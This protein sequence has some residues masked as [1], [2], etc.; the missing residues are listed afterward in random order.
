MVTLSLNVGTSCWLDFNLRPL[1]P[2]LHLS[3]LNWKLTHSTFYW[4]FCS[5]VRPIAKSTRLITCDEWVNDHKLGKVGSELY[6]STNKTTATS[7][8]LFNQIADRFR[9]LWSIISAMQIRDSLHCCSH[10]ASLFSSL[11]AI[12]NEWI[13][14]LEF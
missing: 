3:L 8:E 13:R 6:G 11:L 12:I 1:N 2:T 9:T 7:V 14:D 10:F 4:E 5:T